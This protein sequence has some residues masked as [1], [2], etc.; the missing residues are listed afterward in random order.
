[1]KRRTLRAAHVRNHRAWARGHRS[2]D[3]RYPRL[4]D[5]SL[6]ARDRLQGLAQK[7]LVIEGDAT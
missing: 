3:D 5:A 7:I 4:D 2:D 6:L 1:M